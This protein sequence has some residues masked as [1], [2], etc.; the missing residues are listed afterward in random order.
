[1][2]KSISVILAIVLILSLSVSALALTYLYPNETFDKKDMT[3]VAHRGFSS[4]APENT[5]AAFRLAGQYGFDGIECDILPTQDNKWIVIH[6]ETV[7]RT[8]NGTGNVCDMT[9]EELRFLTVDGGESLDK[10]PDEKLPS[11]EEYLDVC[12]SYKMCALIE[13]KR[14]AND[15]AMN[16]LR[17]IINSYKS[18]VDITVISFSHDALV[19]V[20]SLLPDIKT[21]LVSENL[22]L[23]DNTFIVEKGIDGLDYGCFAAN[24]S[25]L[26]DAVSKGINLGSWPVDTVAE[27]EEQYAYGTRIITTNTLIP[28]AE[29]SRSFFDTLIA[30][31]VKLFKILADILS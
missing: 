8:T 16:N 28:G 30:A 22:K 15:T 14:S 11:L 4:E 12:K 5:L 24:E 17:D 23:E 20:R 18:D 31:L 21:M 2:K 19:A 3:V 26:A 6:D 10:Y 9:Y 1:M 25:V 29:Q 27:A 13:V 7:D